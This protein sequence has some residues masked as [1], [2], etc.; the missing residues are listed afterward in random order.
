M[1]WQ[2]T[3]QEALL[4]TEGVGVKTVIGDGTIEYGSDWTVAD[5]GRAQMHL[6]EDE[7]SRQSYWVMLP[8]SAMG[9]PE[10]KYGVQVRNVTNGNIGV[11]RAID[12][13]STAGG[14]FGITVL[15]VIL[16]R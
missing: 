16:D 14:Q 1:S 9:D 11:L 7:W 15:V 8:A 12:N 2:A 10:L 4:S 3:L 6:H 5:P 13:A